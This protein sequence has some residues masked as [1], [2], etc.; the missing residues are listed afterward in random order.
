LKESPQ[1]SQALIDSHCHFDSEAFKEDRDTVQSNALSVG[2][3]TIISPAITSASWP[4][5]QRIAAQYSHIH[6]AYGLHPMFID[7]HQNADIDALEQW[8][9]R[10]KPV[11]VGECGLDF[12]E[13]KQ[14]QKQ[15]TDYFEAQLSLAHNHQLPIII[16]ARKAVEAVLQSIRRYPDIR[17]VIHSYSGSLE[18]AQQFID[19][20]FYLGFGGPITWPKSTRLQKLIKALPL[21]AILLETDAPDQADASHRGE[22][23]EPSYLPAIAG[24]IASLKKLDYRE[25]ASATTKNA[26]EL[27]RLSPDQIHHEAHERLH[28]S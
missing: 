28:G 24:K 17:G 10:E 2:V 21:E 19:R 11:A 12:Y 4:N 6:P 14:S 25:V 16:H 27:F 26:V 18:Q 5:L 1:N 15:Q 20:G 23:N 7:Q 22:R 9:D 13:S 8:L 3:Q